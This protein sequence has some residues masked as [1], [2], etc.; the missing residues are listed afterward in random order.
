MVGGCSYRRRR[1]DLRLW[2]SRFQNHY[3]P[4]FHHSQKQDA[5]VGHFG[6]K[7]DTGDEYS[8]KAN[9]HLKGENYRVRGNVCVVT[10]F[11]SISQ[12][13]PPVEDLSKWNNLVSSRY[14]LSE[15]SGVIC[16]HPYAKQSGTKMA[17]CKSNTAIW[18]LVCTSYKRKMH[19]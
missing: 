5:L 14:T 19:F 18:G 1:C 2:V 7:S 16:A 13:F 12:S 3:S 17:C 10:Y 8:L 9:R 15:I 6:D 4:N 11:P